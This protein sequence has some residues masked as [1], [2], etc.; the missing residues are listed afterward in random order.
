MTGGEAGHSF[1][2]GVKMDYKKI[3]DQL[4]EKCR[5]RGLNRGSVD[6]YTEIHHILPKCLGGSDE[7]YNLVMFTAKEHYIAHLLL[8]KIYPD[9]HGLY[10]AAFMMG[11]CG[12][13]SRLYAKLREF[14]SITNSARNTGRLKVDYTGQTVGRLLV[15]EYVLDYKINGKRRP[16]WRCLC[17]CGNTTFVATQFLKDGR[18]SSCGCLALDFRKTQHLGKEKPLSVREKISNTLKNKLLKPWQQNNSDQDKWSKANVFFDLWVKNN[19][20]KSKNFANI[21]SCLFNV[22]IKRSYT[23]GLIKEFEQGWIPLEDLDW[24]KFKEEYE[25]L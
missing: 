1:Y 5:V 16:K 22:E 20:P 8:T 11:S 2:L 9:C 6:Y 10:Y 7:E 17:E 25:R 13:N 24:I 4:V 3:Y 19:Y 14:V 15:Q 21:L 18:I 12:R 23:K